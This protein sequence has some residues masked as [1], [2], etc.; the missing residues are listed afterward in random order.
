M[1]DSDTECLTGEPLLKSTSLKRTGGPAN[2]ILST[3]RSSSFSDD[4]ESVFRPFK[5][6]LS[7]ESIEEPARYMQARN[8]R[9]PSTSS[10]NNSKRSHRRSDS[11][12]GNSN[13]DPE[14][15]D[16][17]P[18][19]PQTLLGRS[20][21][22]IESRQGRQEDIAP[23]RMVNSAKTESRRIVSENQEVRVSDNEDM[24]MDHSRM[25]RAHILRYKY[26]TQYHGKMSVIQLLQQRQM[27]SRLPSSLRTSLKYD[28]EPRIQS[29]IVADSKKHAF[30]VYPP[31]T[32]TVSIQCEIM[33]VPE[34]IDKKLQTSVRS[35]DAQCQKMIRTRSHGCQ[36]TGNEI[37]DNQSQTEIKIYIEKEI[38]AVPEYG[39]KNVETFI[40]LFLPP[41]IIMH[42]GGVMEPINNNQIFDTNYNINANKIKSSSVDINYMDNSVNNVFD[43]S[44]M[45]PNLSFGQSTKSSYENYKNDAFANQ[46]NEYNAYNMSEMRNCL[47]SNNIN[48]IPLHSDYIANP[49]NLAAA[50]PNF[51]TNIST[52]NFNQTNVDYNSNNHQNTPASIKGNAL[53]INYAFTKNNLDNNQHEQN[54]S[55][56]NLS[57]SNSFAQKNQLLNSARSRDANSNNYISSTNSQDNSN[58]FDR[59][60]NYAIT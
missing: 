23:R 14:M 59:N 35:V 4:A 54:I 47:Q 9:S 17:L 21:S 3:R 48:Q 12:S 45:K 58:V 44:T 41:G 7:T 13:L 20:V 31:R 50:N 51:Q 19:K 40:E 8:V 28:L 56:N 6:L 11:F 27:Q 37:I 26:P 38:Q 22:R 36:A 33:K 5:K 55:T 49:N 57:Y 2:R 46:S 30:P 43:E 60:Y 42:R 39:S 32:R 15:P 53:G 24:R 25:T 18:R 52:N 34:Q 10:G 1:F 16:I 29:R